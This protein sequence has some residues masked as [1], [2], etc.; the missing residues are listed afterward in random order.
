MLACRKRCSSRVM[1][2]E[3]CLASAKRRGGCSSGRRDGWGSPR[4][5][6]DLSNAPSDQPPI[7][8]LPIARSPYYTATPE[9]EEPVVQQARAHFFNGNTYTQSVKP[10]RTC[11]FLHELRPADRAEV[12]DRSL[13]SVILVLWS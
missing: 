10:D 9:G 13:R 4:L 6:R 7:D 11:F 8:Q 2:L 5:R 3:G 1:R 12:I